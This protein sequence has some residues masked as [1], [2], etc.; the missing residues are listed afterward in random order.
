MK[1]PGVEFFEIAPRFSRTVTAKKCTKK[2]GNARAELLLKLPIS[3]LQRLAQYEKRSLHCIS[4]AAAILLIFIVCFSMFLEAIQESLDCSNDDEEA[5]FAICL[6][7]AA[8]GN[9]GSVE[10]NS[11]LIAND[12]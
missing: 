5:L 3:S 4:G 11:Y 9:K 10:F 12:Y 2:C 7:Y 1:F 8:I 6:L